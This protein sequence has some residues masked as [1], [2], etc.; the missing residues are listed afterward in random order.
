MGM[1][2]RRYDVI[3]PK[4]EFLTDTVILAQA[5]KKSHR[6]IRRH[7][8]YADVLELDCSAVE[9]SVYLDE[10]ANEL[11]AKTYVPRPLRL[12]PAPKSHPWEIGGAHPRGWGPAEGEKPPVLRPLAHL[13]I[14]EQ[15][16][17][18]AVMLCLADC[19]ETAQGDPTSPVGPARARKV[20]SYGNR[21]HCSWVGT[22]YRARARFSWGNSETY[23]RY[24]RDYQKFIDRPVTIARS[25]ELLGGDAVFLVKLDLAAFYDNI[26]IPILISKL[27]A[28]YN[29][30]RLLHPEVP[31]SDPG[32]WH[33]VGEIFRFTWDP[34]DAGLAGLLRDAALPRGLPQGMVASGFFANAY[35]LEFDRRVS[36]AIGG[37]LNFADFQTV[38]LVDYARY[39]DDLRLVIRASTKADVLGLGEAITEW[40]RNQLSSSTGSSAGMNGG[41]QVNQDKTEV[42]PYAATGNKSNIGSRMKAL[43]NDLSGPFDLITLRQAE[44]GLD[45]LLS[46]AEFGTREQTRIRPGSPLSP[47]H[48]IGRPALDVRDDTLTRFAALRLVRVFREQSRM[49][50]VSDEGDANVNRVQK[51]LLHDAEVLTRRLISAWAHNPALVLVLRYA[52]DLFPSGRLGAAVIDALIENI[53]GPMQDR[54]VK[55]VCYYVL[56]ELLRAGATETGLRPSPDTAPLGDIDGYREQ[57]VRGAKRVLLHADTPWYVLQKA[58]LFL[59]SRGAELPVPDTLS[60]VPAHRALLQFVSGQPAEPLPRI[61]EEVAVGLVGFQITK[62]RERFATWFEWVRGHRSQEEISRAADAVGQFDRTLLVHAIRNSRGATAWSPPEYLAREWKSANRGEH[63]APANGRWCQLAQAIA[64]SPNPFGQENG[65]LNLAAALVIKLSQASV[66]PETLTP[67]SVQLKC[68]DW[69]RINDPRSPLLIVSIK[70][71]LAATDPRYVTPTWCEPGREWM[72]AIGRILRAAITGDSDFTARQWLTHEDVGQYLGIQST[73]HKRRFGMMHT[74]AGMGTTTTPITPW[75]TEL[76][77]RCLQWPGTQTEAEFFPEWDSIQNPGDLAKI[78]ATRIEEQKSI[79]GVASQLPIYVYPVQFPSESRDRL[80]VVVVQGLCPSQEEVGR[81]VKG[82][83]GSNFRAKH[84]RHVAALLNLVQKKLLA[85]DSTKE[86]RRIPVA[87]LIV[88]PELSI[89]SGDQDLMRALSDATGAMI[90]FGILDAKD[91]ASG[92][93]VN[94]ARW[95]IPQRRN[96]RRSWILIDQ[97]KW[98][99]TKEEQSIGI[100]PWRPYQVIIELREKNRPGYRIAGSICYDATDLALVSDLRNVSHLFVVAA[101]NKDIRTFDNMVATLNYHMYQHVIIA[102]TGEFG[103]SAAQ[104]PYADEHRR[105]IAHVHGNQQI[106]VSIFEIDRTHFG[107]SMTALIDLPS[108][109]VRAVVNKIGKTS[110]AGL[111]RP[112]ITVKT[113]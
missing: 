66:P 106:A 14:R 63:H 101:M 42:E 69:S 51:G 29:S 59:A 77:V 5:W 23:S 65:I 81:W 91:P 27:R 47:L 105:L 98:H 30:F 100:T 21:L 82:T 19:I 96:D 53:E 6:Y 16:A 46:L 56:A 39:V 36:A 83:A 97:G 113:V 72:Y 95:L 13:G 34:Q 12:I 67:L 89:H 111:R 7:N 84:R 87:D 55:Y 25:E 76:L 38:T 108:S 32:F 3:G 94:V 17:S 28:E 8:W 10:W 54:L 11:R 4:A 68:E 43:Q 20:F 70:P 61:E 88:F 90:F 74:G 107:P 9:L 24:F 41:L 64:S 35:L 22:D 33:L 49:A 92:V 99:L 104:A 110:P 18:T 31:E 78:I 73:W 52:F 45:G 50:D 103:G 60:K 26:D 112:P 40:I 86:H 58:A 80:K 15:V 85:E 75:L 1:V 102:N 57:L 109:T 79:Y 44:A 48:G 37:T 2:K 93:P 71:S 62:S